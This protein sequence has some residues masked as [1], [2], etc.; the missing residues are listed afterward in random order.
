MSRALALAALVVA[1]APASA[2]EWVT[3]VNAVRDGQVVLRFATK[4]GVCGNGENIELRDGDRDDGDRAGRRA[5]GRCDPGPARV[6]LEK[7]GGQ[8]VRVRTTVG[9][10]EPSLRPALD[11]GIVPAPEAARWLLA[12]AEAGEPAGEDLLFAPLLADGVETWPSLLR[13]ARR[14]AL[15]RK[16][17]KAAVFWLGQQA[18]DRVTAELGRLADD[19][20]EELEVREAAVFA[21]SQQPGDRGT[22]ALVRLATGSGDPRVRRRALFWLA[23]R[24][25]PRALAVFEEILARP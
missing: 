16:T 22:E 4:P 3:R 25:D 8:V 23:Q 19:T 10:P 5:D 1:A 20:D 13:I 11:V 18:S 6:A 15:P 21:L 24:D 14:E 9:G 2:Q 12:R 7:R 17:R